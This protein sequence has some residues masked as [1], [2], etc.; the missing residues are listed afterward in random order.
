MDLFDDLWSLH[1]RNHYEYF[2]FWTLFIVINEK[3]Y[4]ILREI[5]TK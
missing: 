5:E 4:F 3:C 1:A 2:A